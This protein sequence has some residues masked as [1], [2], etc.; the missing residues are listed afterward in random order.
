MHSKVW[1]PAATLPFNS[2]PCRCPP[3]RTTARSTQIFYA[4]PPPFGVHLNACVPV[5]ES[6]QSGK[7]HTQCMVH[8]TLP[9]SCLLFVCVVDLH[10]VDLHIVERVVCASSRFGDYASC[11]YLW[12]CF[13]L[14]W[15]ASWRLF[16]EEIL[17]DRSP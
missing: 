13:L 5:D 6:Y 15:T 17:S 16:S 11:A 10:I 4:V 2:Q 12:S 14:A 7:L 1:N 8:F 9:P 3:E